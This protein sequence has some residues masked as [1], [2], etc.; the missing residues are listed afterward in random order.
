M[1]EARALYGLIVDLQIER[2]CGNMMLLG[3][4]AT[5]ADVARIKKVNASLDRAYRSLEAA[6]RRRGVAGGPVPGDM[7]VQ[8][9]HHRERDRDHGGAE[10]KRRREAG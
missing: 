2:A 7:L 6:L 9:P 5:V 1:I 10:H 4:P 3:L 8:Q